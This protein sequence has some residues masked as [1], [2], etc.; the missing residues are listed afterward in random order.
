M[1]FLPQTRSIAGNLYTLLLL[2]VTDE[3][4]GTSSP[5]TILHWQVVNI[6]EGDVTSGEATLSYRAPLPLTGQGDL[7]LMFLLLRQSTA[8]N[9][10]DLTRFAGQSCPQHLRER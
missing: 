4:A 3:L 8:V 1:Q 6:R 7:V 9:A 5:N 10:S 2:D